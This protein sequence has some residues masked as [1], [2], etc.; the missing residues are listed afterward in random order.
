MPGAAILQCEDMPVASLLHL[1]S[2]A[3]PPPHSGGGA[4]GFHSNATGA[5]RPGLLRLVLGTW[6][7]MRRSEYTVELDTGEDYA[8]H[9]ICCTVHTVRA[10]GERLSTRGLIRYYFFLQKVI[11][12]PCYHL[13]VASAT[14]EVIRWVR[15]HGRGSDFVWRRKA[16]TPSGLRW[17]CEETL[18]GRVVQATYCGLGQSRAQASKTCDPP[19]ERHEMRTSGARDAIWLEYTEWRAERRLLQWRRA[20]ANMLVVQRLAAVDVVRMERNCRWAR[21]ADVVEPLCEGCYLHVLRDGGPGPHS[22]G[23]PAFAGP[24]PVAKTTFAK[25]AL[26]ECQFGVDGRSEIIVC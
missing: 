25:A 17:A 7:D 23:C 8:N 19:V 2:T 18:R 4:A 10:S 24:G 11:W 15:A 1:R 20:V 22:L 16:G 6:I 3:L 9:C 21:F 13:D 5:Q 12:N 26:C 14:P